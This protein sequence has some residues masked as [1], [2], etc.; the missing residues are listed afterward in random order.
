MF[1]CNIEEGTVLHIFSKRIPVSYLWQ[2]LA[3]FFENHKNHR[4][5]QLLH[6]KLP[7]LDS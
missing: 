5:Y 3:T 7:C 1:L 2:Q 6:H 4:L